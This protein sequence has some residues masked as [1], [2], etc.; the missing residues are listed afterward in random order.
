MG[1]CLQFFGNRRHDNTYHLFSVGLDGH[2]DGGAGHVFQHGDRD[3]ERLPDWTW[4]GPNQGS[5]PK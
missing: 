3:V 5:E 2:D 1:I 4:P